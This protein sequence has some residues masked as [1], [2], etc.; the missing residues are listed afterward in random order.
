MHVTDEEKDRIAI[1]CDNIKE[2]L[3]A[4]KAIS[5]GQLDEQQS[6]GPIRIFIHLTSNSAED[7]SHQKIYSVTCSSCKKSPVSGFVYHCLQCIDSYDLCGQ[8]GAAGKHPDHVLLRISGD[9]VSYSFTTWKGV[10]DNI[11]HA[12]HRNFLFVN[13]L[14]FLSGAN[15]TTRGQRWRSTFVRDFQPQNQDENLHV[16]SVVINERGYYEPLSFA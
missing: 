15:E 9:M 12:V 3:A 11:L 6:N 5:K 14:A 8:C 10:S 1:P 16:T 13:S 7:K 2:T 4:L